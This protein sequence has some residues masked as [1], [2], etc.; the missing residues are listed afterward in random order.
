[1]R[2]ILK[3]VQKVA[4]AQRKAKTKAIGKLSAAIA[5]PTSL[6][7]KQR[8]QIATRKAKRGPL[9]V[10]GKA[11]VLRVKADKV[12]SGSKAATVTLVTGNQATLFAIARRFQRDHCG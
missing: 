1:M 5:K 2:K 3:Q 10:R 11:M 7:V 6:P 9:L 4:K 8:Q 12:V